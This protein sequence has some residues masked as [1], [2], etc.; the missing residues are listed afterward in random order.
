MKYGEVVR[1]AVA[2]VIAGAFIWTG[3]FRLPNSQPV[4]FRHPPVI[5]YSEP[6]IRPLVVT[7]ER[8]L[9][10]HILPTLPHLRSRFERASIGQQVR[11]A[12]TQY[13][14]QGTTRRDHWVREGIVAA[15]PKVFPLAHY[16]E[17]SLGRHYLGRFLIDDTGGKVKGAHLDIWTPSC[18]DARRFGRQHGTAT[19]VV[20]PEN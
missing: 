3:A 19:L 17:V 10:H 4:P 8:V 14:L 18:S 20:K 11:V 5:V 9:P 2:A 16:V 15:D 13:C 12:L 1:V 6:M 7:A